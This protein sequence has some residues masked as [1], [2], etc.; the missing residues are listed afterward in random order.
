MRRGC[1][2]SF[3]RSMPE[4]FNN[5][6]GQYVSNAMEFTDQLKRQSEAQSIRTGMDHNYVP[7]DVTEMKA[8]GVTD[9]GLE[10]THRRHFDGKANQ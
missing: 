1:S 3:R 7:V 2:F 9:D 6:T 4:H 8:L 10:E 5:S